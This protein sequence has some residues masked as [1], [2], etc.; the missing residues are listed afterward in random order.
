M[1][2]SH[3]CRL[4]GIGATPAWLEGGVGGGWGGP[5]PRGLVA[6]SV[7]AANDAKRCRVDVRGVAVQCLIYN[8]VIRRTFSARKNPLRRDF[9]AQGSTRRSRP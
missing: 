4:H 6:P 5:F 1:C 2:A 7:T 8:F 9:Y 3:R